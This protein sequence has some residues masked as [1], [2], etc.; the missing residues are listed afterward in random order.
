MQPGED[1]LQLD[2][3]EVILALSGGEMVPNG[4]EH[5]VQVIGLQVP[6]SLREHLHIGVDSL[7]NIIKTQPFDVLI[8][9]KMHFWPLDFRFRWGFGQRLF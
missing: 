2:V 9:V 4:R 3:L 7:Q 1:S 5:K 8:S 6:I